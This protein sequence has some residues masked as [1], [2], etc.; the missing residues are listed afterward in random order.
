MDACSLAEVAVLLWL[1]RRR[2]KKRKRIWMH[3]L[4]TKRPNFRSFCHLFP[5]LVNCPEKFYN[6]FRMTHEKSKKLEELTESSIKKIS[7]YYRRAAGVE[8]RM[9]I[10]LKETSLA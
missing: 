10:F 8:E 6:F 1:R 5:D 7:T 2:R 4:N 9:A 3:E